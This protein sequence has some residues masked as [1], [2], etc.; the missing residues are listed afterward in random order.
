MV[1]PLKSVLLVWSG[2]GRERTSLGLRLFLAGLAEPRWIWAQ[3][4]D[5]A[6]GCSRSSSAG[7][8]AGINAGITAAKSLGSAQCICSWGSL[9]PAPLGSAHGDQCW[10]HYCQIP[11]ICSWES[12][13]PALMGS[14][15]G[16][17]CCHTTTAASPRDSLARSHGQHFNCC[18]TQ[19]S[20]VLI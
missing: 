13:L 10:D 11:G 9:L 6:R 7:I 1:L 3:P 8:T 20:T 17:R 4:G 14:A 12:L 2:H 19:G 16:N 18:P 5:A 15:P